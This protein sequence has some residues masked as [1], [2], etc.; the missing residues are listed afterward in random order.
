MCGIMRV[1]HVVSLVYDGLLV[2]VKEQFI[3]L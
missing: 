3:S 2:V 1:D